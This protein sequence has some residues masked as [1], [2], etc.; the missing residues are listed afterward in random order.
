M[1][2]KYVT[3]LGKTSFRIHIIISFIIQ[4]LFATAVCFLILVFNF[5][6]HEERTLYFLLLILILNLA[7]AWYV[8]DVHRYRARFKD[9]YPDY[10]LSYVTYL[11]LGFAPFLFLAFTLLLCS[12]ES[13]RL[14]PPPKFLKKRF[15]LSAMFALWGLQFS[16]PKISYWSA[17]PSIYYIVD[18]IH[19]TFR[20]IDLKEKGDY[21]SVINELYQANVSTTKNV[22][23]IASAAVLS[24]ND[25]NKAITN[26]SDRHN[27]FMKSGL[28]LTKFCY[29]SLIASESSRFNFFY[30]S[31]MQWLSFSGP[32]EI[33][34]LTIIDQQIVKAFNKSV[35]EKSLHVLDRLEEKSRSGLYRKQILELKNRFAQTKTFR[36]QSSL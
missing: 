13:D 28:Q 4:F 20:V 16:S 34:L 1:K 31:P 14:R 9:I 8:F 6:L 18:V 15:I 2:L 29:R 11:L 30:Y 32:I 27:E 3:P 24:L 5:K 23:L 12:Q 36:D 10:D 19:D 7:G 35:L 26:G 33:L 21:Q 25:R 22:L 17:S